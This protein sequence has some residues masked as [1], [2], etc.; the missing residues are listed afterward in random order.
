[1]I[2]FRTAPVT[3]A[4]L[5]A[6]MLASTLAAAQSPT[7]AQLGSDPIYGL[8]GNVL[9]RRQRVV[10]LKPVECPASQPRRRIRDERS[11]LPGQH[12]GVE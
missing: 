1:M 11:V 8:V 2:K 4:A 12:Y 6:L 5:A 7:C 9:V 10:T 3:L